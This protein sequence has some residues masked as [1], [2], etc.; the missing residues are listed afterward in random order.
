MEEEEEEQDEERRRGAGERSWLR[1]DLQRLRGRDQ[2]RG[3]KGLA[4]L[5]PFL[6]AP[7]GSP[8]QVK[9][10]GGTGSGAWHLLTTSWVP[11]GVVRQ[12]HRFVE[13]VEVIQQCLLL[14]DRSWYA[15]ATDHAGTWR[16]N[17]LCGTSHRCS[18][19]TRLMTAH[20]C[21]VLVLVQTVHSLRSSWTRSLTCPLLY[22]D[23]CMRL[24]RA[25]N[26][27]GP[28]VATL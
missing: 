6:G 12:H 26:C 28:A 20:C 8:G 1:A 16:W 3:S 5:G 11:C 22:N 14:R 21:A 9:C 4:S 7:A 23:R 19:W 24:D 27:G 13:D 18:S 2:V 25:E 15:S 17:S 10:A